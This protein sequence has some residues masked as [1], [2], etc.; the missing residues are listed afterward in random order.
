MGYTAEELAT[1]PEGANVGLSCGSPN[2]LAALKP[3]E[4]VLD[5]GSGDGFDVFIAARK[6]GAA[7]RAKEE[8][9]GLGPWLRPDYRHPRGARTQ[10]TALAVAVEPEAKPG[11]RKRPWTAGFKMGLAVLRFKAHTSIWRFRIIERSP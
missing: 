7:R 10:Q 4:V 11:K 2:A 5:L 3:G 8:T 9:V 1:L 6:V